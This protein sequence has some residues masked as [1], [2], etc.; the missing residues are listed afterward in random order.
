MSGLHDMPREIQV[1]QLENC[2]VDDALKNLEGF[3]FPT[4]EDERTVQEMMMAFERYAI[5]EI[6]ETLEIYKFGK[7]QQQEG[8]SMN[9]F[10]A[11]LRT[12]RKP[13]NTVRDVS[14]PYSANG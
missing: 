12:L 7:R 4:G 13:V 3:D 10:L 9:T 6:H 1:A 11:D 5:G 14:L 8:E 2:L